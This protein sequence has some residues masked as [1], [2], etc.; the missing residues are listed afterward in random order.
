MSETKKSNAKTVASALI[1]FQL[2]YNSPFLDISKG[3]INKL[4]L[5]QNT[6]VRVATGLN[7]RYHITPEHRSY[8]S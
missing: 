6:V 4:Q 5:I 8:M 1:G 2:E 7:W 3:S